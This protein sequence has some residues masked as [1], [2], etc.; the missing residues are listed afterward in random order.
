VELLTVGAGEMTAIKH[1]AVCFCTY[2]RAHLLPRLLEE[3]GRQDTSGLFTYSIVVVDNDAERSAESVVMSIGAKLSVPISYFVEARQ[4]IS[5]ARNKAVENASGDFLAF[6]DD[7]EFPTK[8]WLLTLFS[9]CDKRNVDGVLGPVM[10]Y[11]QESPPRWVTDGKFCERQTY[12]TG[13]VIDGSKGRTGNVLLKKQIFIDGELPFNPEFTA[14][15]DQ[16]FFGRMIARGHVFIWC[17]EAVAYEIVPPAR[18]TRRFMLRRALLRG[19]MQPQSLGFGIRSVLKSLV[20]V[21]A[22]F[23]VLPLTLVLGHHRFMSVLVRICDHLGKLL[24]LAGI[25]PIKGQYVTE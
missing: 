22:Y 3:L 13:Y 9:T 5:H 19:A 2:R 10:P 17:H 8:N 4:G 23:V 6:I 24:A 21:P 16:D 7:D 14:G 11:F 1:I 12:P 20:A 15:E 25:N 18:W